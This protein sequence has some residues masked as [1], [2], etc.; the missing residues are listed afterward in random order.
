MAT[1]QVDVFCLLAMLFHA[2]MISIGSGNGTISSESVDTGIFFNGTYIIGGLF[3]IHYASKNITTSAKCYGKFSLEGFLNMEAM[4]DAVHEINKDDHLL[5]GIRLGVNIEDTCSSVDTAI[6]KS[7]N[8]TFIKRNIRS[9]DCPNDDLLNDVDASPTVAIIGPYSSDVA[10]AVTNFAGLFYVPV[11]SFSA[12]SRLLSNRIRF[13]YFLRT[14]SSDAQMAMVVVHLLQALKWN[15]VSALYSDTDYGRSAIETLEDVL[16]S[17]PAADKICLAVK[18][19]FTIHST[20]S[21]LNEILDAVK[22]KPDAKGVILFTTVEDAK[23]ILAEFESKKMTE[24]V[25]IGMDDLLGDLEGVQLSTE[26]LLRLIG[27]TP[28]I[29]THRKRKRSVV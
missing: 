20:K 10:M 4:L 2:K 9:T 8:F 24:Y 26:M 7:L 1:S 25:F 12:S 22:A 23:L 11:V 14:I 13:R 3:P 5:P 6:R 21:K 16:K 27:V 19:S 17:L 18:R 29:Q 15:F 28:K